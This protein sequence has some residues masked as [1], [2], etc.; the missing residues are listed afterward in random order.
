MIGIPIKSNLEISSSSGITPYN[1]KEAC[2][3]SNH[4]TGARVDT[5]SNEVRVRSGSG[6]YP[7]NGTNAID[8][9]E[10]YDYS[11]YVYSENESSWY[12][13]ETLTKTFSGA[14]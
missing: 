3:A 10:A 5:V 4:L 2:A 8:F 7:A 12:P 6:L 13:E 11:S 9:G 1:S 14:K